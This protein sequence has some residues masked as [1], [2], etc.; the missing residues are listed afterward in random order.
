MSATEVVFCISILYWY[1]INFLYRRFSVKLALSLCE[2]FGS[3]RVRGPIWQGNVALT[4]A[5]QVEFKFFSDA[6]PKKAVFLA[7]QYNLKI[8]GTLVHVIPILPLG[9]SGACLHHGKQHGRQY[10]LGKR[11]FVDPM[12]NKYIIWRE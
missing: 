7:T 8:P 1:I 3:C 2:W 9:M 10:Q 12:E 4:Q 5:R 11:L 6:C